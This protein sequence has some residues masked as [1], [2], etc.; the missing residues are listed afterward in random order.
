MEIREYLSDADVSPFARWFE[1]LNTPAAL[2]V[3]T[4]LA[5]MGAGNLTNAKSVG[6]GVHECRIDFGPGYRLYFGKDGTRL[7]I[8]LGGGTKKRQD[9]DVA[10][11]K[12]YWRAYKSRKRTEG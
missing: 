6:A 3:R 11:A 4:A 12:I 1:A 5:R 8:L 9:R 10:T 7:V 2:K